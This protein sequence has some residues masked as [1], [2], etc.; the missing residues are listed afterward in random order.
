[1]EAADDLPPL[2]MLYFGY[3][4]AEQEG[5]QRNAAMP[6]EGSIGHVQDTPSAA[7]GS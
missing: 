3:R 2:T 1:M 6:R 4:D 7:A 5:K